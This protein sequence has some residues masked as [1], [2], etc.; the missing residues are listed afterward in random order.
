MSAPDPLDVHSN[1]PRNVFQHIHICV[2]VKDL[3]L[4]TKQ[5]ILL[6]YRR[7]IYLNYRNCDTAYYTSLHN[8]LIGENFISTIEKFSAENRKIK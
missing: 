7:K 1:I 8:D 4:K 6:Q 3:V 2:C 5:K